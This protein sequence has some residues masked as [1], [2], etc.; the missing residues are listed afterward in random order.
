MKPLD[1]LNT[2][3]SREY[4]EIRVRP[5]TKKGL[6]QLENWF[7]NQTWA[8]IL[9]IKDVNKKASLLHEMILEKVELFLPEKT[10]KFASDDQPWYSKE[11]KSLDHKRRREYA[12]NRKSTK[13]FALK[14]LY[15]KKDKFAKSTFK[16]S[17]INDT[18]RAGS[19]VWYKKFKRMSNYDTNQ[20]GHL[21]VSDIDHLSP[22]QQ[23]EEIAN[24]FS[25]SRL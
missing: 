25:F 22:L 24:K 6:S 3:C 10:I 16:K 1:S 23:A 17:I 8:E 11:L 7:S 5:M 20:F 4:R 12:K 15:D 9:N 14:K 13:Y 21:K 19:H 18:I 2:K